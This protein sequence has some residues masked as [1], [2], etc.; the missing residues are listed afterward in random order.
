[1][2]RARATV[3]AVFV[4]A[5]LLGPCIS[6]MPF[7][8]AAVDPSVFGSGVGRFQSL[9]S[10]DLDGDGAHEVLFGSYEGRVVQLQYRAG[11]FFVEWQSPKMGDRCW[12]LRVGDCDNDGRN[13]IVVGDGNGDLYV[14]DAKSHKLEWKAQDQMVRDAHGIAI[15]DLDGD[16]STEIVVGTGY[17]TDQDYGTIYV[18][19]GKGTGGKPL[20]SFG[21]YDSRLRGLEVADL[22]GDGTM[23]IAVGSGANLGDIEGRGYIRVLDA[24][25]GSIEWESAD[26]GG[27]CEGLVLSDIDLDGRPNLIVGEGYRYREGHVHVLQ[28]DNATRGYAEQWRSDDIGPK[29]WGVAVGDCDGDGTPEIVVGNQPG[30]VRIFDASSHAL[31][32]QSQ[33]LGTD[34]F[35]ACIDDVDGDGREEVVLA[36]GGYQGKGD[37][38]S[39]YTTPHIYVLDGSTHRFEYVLGE[40]NIWGMVLLVALLVLII[41]ALLEV[42]LL[43]KR[44]RLRKAERA[45]A[46]AAGERAA[47]AAGAPGG[48]E[49]ECGIPGWKVDTGEGPDD[50]AGPQGPAGGGGK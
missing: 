16:G 34:I 36:Q 37:F 10:G 8:Q 44:Y 23:E 14:Y 49:A 32:W 42:G 11:D 18:W 27:D 45:K 15:A 35:G 6:V 25:T 21:P 38:T 24:V 33:L 17:K 41:V 3:P 29:A 50:E 2:M 9:Y 28:Y 19:S 46:A 4:T 26:L 39:G 43:T 12:G 20:R 31:E 40:R 22:D 13:E 48:A 1:M 7:V 5:L 47:R 30:Y